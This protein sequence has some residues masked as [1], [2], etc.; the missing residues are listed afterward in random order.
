M[1]PTRPD[2]GPSLLGRDA[3]LGALFAQLDDAGA[4]GR[5]IGLLGEAGV[6]KSALLAAAVDHARGHG[7]TVLV[8]RGSQSETHLPFAGLHQ[9]LR[10]L[11]ANADRLPGMQ[12]DALLACFAMSD[13]AAENPH[14]RPAP[15]PPAQTPPASGFFAYLATLELIVD[16]SSRAP[17]LVGLDDLQWMDQPS[18]DAL[19][20]V[21]RRI[22]G[23]RVVLLCTARPGPPSIDAQT[24]GWT[25]LHGIDDDAAAA[26]LD[27]RAPGLAPA[28]RERVLRQARGNPLALMEFAEAVESGRH[29]GGDLDDELPMTT[30]LERAFAARA[31]HLGAAVRAILTVAAIDDGD[32]FDDVLA[33]A[34]ALHGAPLDRAAARPAFEHGLLSGGGEQYTIRHP[35]VGSALRQTMP[36]AVREQAHRA[37][38]AVLP[39]HSDRAVWHRAAAVAG[40]D[41]TVA[42]ELER[43]AGNARRRG[44]IAS[45]AAWLERAAALSPDPQ[46]RAGR[47]L[48]AAELGYQLGR[49]GQ[50]EQIKAQVGGMDLRARD[51][52]R[53]AW[54]DGV[55]HDGS[56]GEPAEVR[57]LLDMARRATGDGDLDLAV[58]LLVGAARRAWWRDPGAE[59]RHDIVLAARRTA[60]PEDDP[61]LLAICALS[62]PNEEGPAV[63]EQLGRWSADADGRPDLAGLLGIAAFCT[64]D[65]RR[66]A[67]FLSSPINELRAQGRMSLLAEALAIRAWAEVYLGTFDVSRSA[68]EAMRL[69][70]ETGQSLWAA[71]ARI[72]IA[73]IDGVGRGWDTRHELLTDAQ[74]VALRTPNAASSLLAG[75]QLARGIAEL[76]ANRPEQAFGELRRVFQPDDPAFQHVQQV[77]TLSHLADAA[78]PIGRHAEAR[79]A[80]AAVEAVAGGSPATGAKLAL[81]YSR[82]V[83]AGASQ[84]EPLFRAALDGESRHL[85]WHR[86]RAELAYGTW[87]RRRRRVLESRD[88]LRA[89]RATFEAVGA[90]TWAQRADRELRATGERGWQPTSS[91]RER[92]SPQEAQIAEL[93]AEGLSNREIG[94]R[95]FLSHRT[96]STHLYRIFPKLGIT[97]RGRLAAALSAT[98]TDT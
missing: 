33:A 27:A 3:E 95:L 81:E 34:A 9:V 76:G 65:F 38:A 5:A 79:A 93:A 36:A 69:A 56:T 41:E 21:A 23:E 25:Q 63:I 7:F 10:P 6:G 85:P 60:L 70:D 31:E 87:L 55:F 24:V 66:A 29:A 19:A 15:A 74:H 68:D 86:A 20:F 82:A 94:Q 96:V 1:P 83:L 75:V 71:T 28:V 59:L 51:R 11:L 45:A 46:D 32:N 16:A 54:L 52:S 26:L 30:R 17:V 4:Q 50:V 77:W 18:I 73:L 98:R 44:A 88:P 48:S 49:H 35:L 97:S 53:L 61:A 58:Q 72:A 22:A 47:L 8:A 13:D 91:P 64:G 37:L 67:A 89:A 78:V 57:H 84:A 40:R 14:D 62:E 42:A 92:L 2:P 39:A 90:R 80:L 12:R 43:A